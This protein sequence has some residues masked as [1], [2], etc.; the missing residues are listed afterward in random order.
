MST[1]EIPLLQGW[2]TIPEAARRTGV[3]RQR[4]H[5]LVHAGTGVF[6][7]AR[8]V[9]DSTVIVVPEDAVKEAE[10]KFD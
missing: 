1:K 9:G 2:V 5:Q 3:S 8:R 10:K 4:A 6:K 7:D